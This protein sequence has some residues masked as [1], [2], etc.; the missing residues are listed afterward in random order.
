MM[1]FPVRKVQGVLSCKKRFMVIFDTK[2]SRLSFAAFEKGERSGRLSWGDR[3]RD[4][5]AG[6][7]LWT[8]HSTRGYCVPMMRE[9]V[10]QAGIVAGT[11]K[12]LNLNSVFLAFQ[13]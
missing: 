12:K 5:E 7:G 11:T 3:N 9:P 4:R 8:A 1:H 6:P 10:K 13:T 2:K